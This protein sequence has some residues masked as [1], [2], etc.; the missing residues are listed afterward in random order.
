[1]PPG[2]GRHD[3]AIDQAIYEWV[4][5]VRCIDGQPPVEAGLRTAPVA[6]NKLTPVTPVTDGNPVVV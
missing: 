4:E 1:V 2:T 6:S 3:G 5:K